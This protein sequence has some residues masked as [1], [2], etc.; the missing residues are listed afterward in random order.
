MSTTSTRAPSR[1]NARHVAAP[2]P[3]APP[4]TTTTRPANRPEPSLI[5][6]V[7][8]HER[9]HRRDV[10]PESRLGPKDRVGRG[11]PL[12]FRIVDR[13]DDREP[14]DAGRI[15]HRTE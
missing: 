3:L 11:D 13:A 4:V 14:V 7:P 6:V 15:E 10:E 1:A 12:R 2:M 9:H 8:R 5:D